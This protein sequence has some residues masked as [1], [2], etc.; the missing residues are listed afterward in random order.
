MSAVLWCTS[1]L[2]VLGMLADPAGSAN[3]FCP[4]ALALPV[5]AEHR[6]DP[7]A[8]AALKGCS[9]EALYYGIGKPAD[10]ERARQCAFLELDAGDGVVFGGSAMLMTI[11]ANGVGAPRN[12]DLALRFACLVAS[13][14]AELEA[15]VDRLRRMKREQW[16]GT[17][18]HLCDEI[19]SGSMGGHCAAHDQ[20]KKQPRRDAKVRGLLA[21]FSDADRAAFTRLRAAA[22]SYFKARTSNEVDL[23][24]TARGAL[25]IAE[26]NALEKS[27]AAALDHLEKKRTLPAKVP[28]LA[29]TDAALNVEYRR[30][31]A[32]K[33]PIWG[34]VDKAGITRT[35]RLWLKYRD[36]FVAFARQRYPTLPSDQL[37][38]WLTGVRTGML[39]EFGE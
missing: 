29:E 18:F 33:E 11:Y 19:T 12:L 21:S 15:R 6:P 10:P 36:A 14:P 38:S 16:K 9:S 2:A 32:V 1:S 35:Q 25:V 20:R 34:T 28:P 37:Q 8:A 27:L 4:A 30:V 31:Q 24:G 22:D 7:T 3:P 13:A 5:P 26:E 17:N 23:S 39:K